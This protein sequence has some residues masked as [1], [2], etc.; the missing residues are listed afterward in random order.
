VLPG[1]AGDDYAVE[2]YEPVK[3]SA[4][5]NGALDIEGAI[6]PLGR[7]PTGFFVARISPGRAER[8]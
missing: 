2:C 6:S 4:T 3:D 7:V 8:S 1:V 5:L